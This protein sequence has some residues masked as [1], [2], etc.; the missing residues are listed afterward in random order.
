MRRNRAELW[1]T[2]A[3]SGYAN[4]DRGVI[5]HLGFIKGDRVSEGLGS[6]FKLK[7]H[8]PWYSEVDPVE[9]AGVRVLVPIVSVFLIRNLSAAAE[10]RFP[11][12]LCRRGVRTRWLVLACLDVMTALACQ[13]KVPITCCY[14]SSV[15]TIREGV[16]DDWRQ[17]RL[18]IL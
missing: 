12:R 17:R 18:G 2:W 14:K 9:P 8:P 13:K 1:G 11:D 16:G 4:P 15:Q 3:F 7:D 5:R 10:Q 6:S